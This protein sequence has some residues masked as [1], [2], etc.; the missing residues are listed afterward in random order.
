MTGILLILAAV[1][2]GLTVIRGVTAYDGLSLLAVAF[3]IAAVLS[4][5]IRGAVRRGHR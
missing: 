4:A 5:L 2:A 1:C 3:I